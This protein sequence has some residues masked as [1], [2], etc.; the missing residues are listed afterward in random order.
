MN[1]NS[2][3]NTAPERSLENPTKKFIVIIDDE[4]GIRSFVSR[5]VEKKSTD[6]DFNVSAQAFADRGGALDFLNT[7]QGEEEVLVL[8]DYKMKG[9]KVSVIHFLDQVKG[10]KTVK[11][12]VQSGEDLSNELPEGTHFILKEGEKN[13]QRAIDNFLGIEQE[14]T[15]ENFDDNSIQIVFVDEKE[16]RIKEIRDL[17]KDLIGEMGEVPK[18][19]FRPFQSREEALEFIKNIKDNQSVIVVS[20]VFK[21]P[22][23][24]DA[25]S[26]ANQLRKILDEKRKALIVFYTTKIKE[27]L[28]KMPELHPGHKE[29][30]TD[31]FLDFH[32]NLRTGLYAALINLFSGNG[33]GNIKRASIIQEINY[34]NN[35]NNKPFADLF[36][37][38]S[39]NP[40]IRWGF[41]QPF[42]AQQISD[43]RENIDDPNEP[44]CFLDV[45]AGRGYP[46]IQMERERHTLTGGGSMI[47]C[48]NEHDPNLGKI[49]SENLRNK[50]IFSNINRLTNRKW[51]NLRLG[52]ASNGGYDENAMDIIACLGNSLC[53]AEDLEEHIRSLQ[54]MNR[55]LKE[56]GE[57]WLD[58]RNW[59]PIRRVAERVLASTSNPTAEDFRGM[60]SSAPVYNGDIQA[61][62]VAISDNTITYRYCHPVDPSQDAYVTYRTYSRD[63]ILYMLGQ[64]GFDMNVK[65]FHNYR[66]THDP[67]EQAAAGFMQYVARKK[68]S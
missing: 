35:R 27:A 17:L 48:A 64:A 44:I 58:S 36:E 50:E 67:E 9:D 15:A 6:T 33:N 47:L 31:V 13:I 53:Y 43:Y 38:F 54:T 18:H 46:I 7:L 23:G 3:Q 51:S 52:G 56:G 4:S 19:L 1:K 29:S 49:L 61:F 2:H 30:K 11:V 40:E 65:V 32:Q 37:A 34:R 8:L 24:P 14:D 26:F 66:E 63:N 21:H 41:E 12:I 57:L 22:D 28:E 55:V 25:V 60:P 42:F 20:D 10:I 62:P 59:S 16:A 39:G 5:Y 68:I 45:C